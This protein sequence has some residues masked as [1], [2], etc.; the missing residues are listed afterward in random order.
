MKYDWTIMVSIGNEKLWVQILTGA[1]K[2]LE[3]TSGIHK[4]MNIKMPEKCF[5]DGIDPFVLGWIFSIYEMTV[6]E[7]SNA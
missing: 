4:S 2:N 7:N 6:Y 1:W 3:D 5:L